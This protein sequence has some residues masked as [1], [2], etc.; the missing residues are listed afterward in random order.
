MV[1]NRGIVVS[2]WGFCYSLGRK[3]EPY[4]VLMTLGSETAHICD[5]LM[6]SLT[7]FL[8]L[9]QLLVP[10]L[11]EHI[12]KNLRKIVINLAAFLI[13]LLP[14]C[15]HLIF[16]YVIKWNLLISVKILF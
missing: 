3:W 15:T 1:F 4:L 8:Q 5:V 10:V 7:L 12:K 9:R 6:S 13:L 2:V 16:Y 14:V 11:L